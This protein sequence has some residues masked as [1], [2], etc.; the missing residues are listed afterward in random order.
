MVLPRIEMQKKREG[1][2]GRAGTATQQEGLQDFSSDQ[3]QGRSNDRHVQHDVIV[4]GAATDQQ[5][6]TTVHLV[7]FA[8]HAACL[9]P[10]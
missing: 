7:S 9:I 2:A 1:P 3:G 4:S 8:L 10:L 5:Q 6:K